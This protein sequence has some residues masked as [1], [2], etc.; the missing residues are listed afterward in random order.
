M[1]AAHRK[2]LEELLRVKKEEVAKIERE[3]KEISDDE[4]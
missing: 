4:V 1:T 2:Y 3:L